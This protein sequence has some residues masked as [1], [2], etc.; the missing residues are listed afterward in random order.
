VRRGVLVLFCVIG[1]AATAAAQG[2][3][4][5]RAGNAALD[6]GRLDVAEARYREAARDQDTAALAWFNL[7]VVMAARGQDA[8]AA[9]TF[10]GAAERAASNAG[11][12]RAQYNRGVVL[13]R[14]GQLREALGAFMEALRREPNHADARTN[15]AVVRARLERQSRG[16]STPPPDAAD[17]TKQALEQVPAQSFAFTRGTPKSRPVRAGDDW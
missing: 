6:A 1:Y 13:A 15:F 8:L 17:E 3:D 7:G 9:R 12:A 10:S 11:K 16:P 4:A 5:L 2:L 14:S